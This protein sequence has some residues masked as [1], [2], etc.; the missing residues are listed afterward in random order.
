MALRKKKKKKK[1]NF[2]A[3]PANRKGLLKADMQAPEVSKEGKDTVDPL[4]V[5][6][7]TYLCIDQDKVQR[8]QM[9]AWGKC[10]CGQV[11]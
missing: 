4:Q 3:I 2:L 5:E 1:S 7:K 11:M 8:K 10:S 9:A 6:M